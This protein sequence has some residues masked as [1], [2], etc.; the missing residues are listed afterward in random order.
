MKIHIVSHTHWDREWY[1]PFQY[2]KV[3]LSYFFDKLFDVLEKDNEYAHFMLDGQMVMIEDYL[4]LEPQNKDK[5]KE[6]VKQ[7][8]L[9]IGPW[10]SQ[11]DEFAPSGE[12]LVRNLL[13][14]I[15]MASE[16]GDWMKVGYLPDS[17]G[18]SCQM[19]Q[20]LKGCNIGA[21]CVMR[22]VPANKLTRTEFMWRGLNSDEVLTVALPKGY[23]NGMFLPIENMAIDM[24][25]KKIIEDI[26]QVGNEKNILVMN[27][28][29]HQFPQPQIAEYIKSKIND[30]DEY[31]HSTLEEY[32]EDARE[33]TS[34][35]IKL[36]GELIAPVTNRVHT[37]IASSRMYQKGKN[38]QME[39]LLA[40]SVEPLCTLSYIMGA[41]YPTAI[42]NSAWKEMFKNQAHDSICGCCTD[43]VHREIDQ[44][45]ADI[46]NMGMTLTKMHSRAIASVLAGDNPVLVVFNDSM[47]KGMQVV[48]ATVYIESDT[49]ALI[50]EQGYEVDYTIEKSDKIDA[51]SLS[52]WSLYME[53]PC[54]VNKFDISFVI[55]FDF[56]YGY[57]KLNIIEG[58]KPQND[59]KC[60]DIE[61]RTLENEFSVVTLNNDGT[62]NLFDKQSNNEYFDLN[63]IEDCGDA[64]DTYNYSPVEND[65]VVTNKAV[66]DCD[67]KV[68]RYYSKTTAILRYHLNIPEELSLDG[69]SRSDKEL[70]LEIET[71]ISLHNS[72]KRIDIETKVTN[73]AKDHRI[74][75][76]FPTGIKSDYSYAETQFGTIKRSNIFK[77]AHLWQDEKWAEKPLPIYSNHKFV[78]VNNG[79]NGVAVFNKG[80][81]EYEIYQ[82]NG[83]SIAITLLRGVGYMGKPDL[84]IRPGRPSGVGVETPDAQCLGEHLFKYSILI[85]DGDADNEKIAQQAAI[86]NAEPTTAQNE[87]KLRAITEK[88]GSM[89]S[90]FD[91]ERLQHCAE[92]KLEL[93]NKTDFKLIDIGDDRLIV[94]TFKRAEKEDAVILRVYNSSSDAIEGAMISIGWD[95]SKVYECD[96][97]ENNL[98]ELVC[99]GNIFMTNKIPRYTAKTY[100][101]II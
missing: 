26:K 96:F 38:R 10:Y 68:K 95:I 9:I 16:Y 81:T 94:S 39:T 36:D 46:E 55:D 35:L 12:S 54:M 31:L 58:Q 79:S 85:H 66:A 47:V 37:S 88:F 100:K 51:A 49:F 52:I 8:R 90:L 53:T 24:R 83:S 97:V 29:D 67:S 43:E 4:N 15:N 75:A 69:K 92:E 82:Q 7:G 70:S 80:L 77:D 62:F 76:I 14:G 1:R 72:I 89:I 60:I 25:A 87:I 78:Y 42:I 45:F 18:Q 5:I 98:A 63:T 86:Y 13:V 64:G 65:R 99:E 93:E 91:M 50:N 32:I 101:I 40:N 56:N 17:F 61:T 22:G 30:S 21:A 20:I 84:A 6:F 19:P 28:V 48:N 57:K 27:G 44:R 73:N 3:K 74:R 23:S 71:K 41:K 11:P 59:T 2:F 34:G 33:D